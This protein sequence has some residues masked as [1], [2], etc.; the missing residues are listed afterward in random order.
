MNSFYFSFFRTKAFIL[1]LVTAFF[2][3]YAMAQKPKE[4]NP[5]E[6]SLATDEKIDTEIRGNMS[7]NLDNGLPM[8]IYQVNFDVPAGTPE[9][10]AMYYL[11]HQH[12]KLG[13]PQNELSNLRHHATRTSRA[14][15]VVRYR[16]YSG[17][18][19]V[20]KAE[21]TITIS[22][23]NKVVYVMNS[24]E[25]NVNMANTQPSISQEVAY[26]LANDYLNI[27]GNIMF[28]DYRL[29]VY[30]NK[31]TTRLAYEVVIS[32]EGLSGEWHVYVDA[33][34][35]E[36]FKAV[37]MAHY[38]G[39]KDKDKKKKNSE[40]RMAVPVDGTG[41]VFNP[42]PLSSNQVNYGGGYVD[43]NDAAT[44]QLNNARFSV[45]LRDIDLTGGIYT[46]R[47]PR[48]EI[49]DFEGPTTGLFTQTSS[50]FNFTRFDQGFEAVNTYYHIDF[51]MGYVNE[52]LGLNI[53]PYQYTGGV[54]YDPHAAG[55][56]DNSYYSSGPGRL[57]F[58]EGCVDDAE[59]SD[60]IHHEL[61]HG[62]HDWVTSGGLSQVDGLSEGCGDY[63]AQSYN[64][65]LG[66]WTSA[67]PQY[68]WVFNWDGHNPCWPGRITN[69][70][71][72]YPTGLVGQIHTDGQI[73]ASCLMGIWDQIGQQEM[74]I[75][76]YEGLG[77][78][79]GSSSQN[80]AANAVY[81]AAV[82][83]NYTQAQLVIIHSSLEDCGYTLPAL[84]GPPIASFSSDTDTICLDN[85]TTI[86]FTDTTSPTATSWLWTFEGGT[87]A[88]STAQ[89]P[90]VTY[91]TEGT[92]DV[93][94][95]VTNEFGTDQVTITDYVTTL[96]GDNCPACTSSTNSTVVPISTGAGATYTSII[97][98]PGGG[99]IIDVNVTIN[100]THTWVSDLDISLISPAGTI[101]ELTSDNGDDGNNYINTVFD[102][103][104]TT[105][106]TSGTPPFTGTFLPEGNLSNLNGQDAAGNWTLRVVDDAF[107]DGGQI[108]S[109]TLD[110]CVEPPLSVNENE[111]EAFSIFPNPNDGSFTI[112]LNSS[113]GNNINVE[114]YDV[115]GR[116]IFKNVYATSANFNENISLK[117]VQSGMYLVKVSDGEREVTR[118]VIVE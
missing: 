83:L 16:Q 72:V 81:Q 76:F 58:G 6:I 65:S 52:T 35:Q 82:N 111:F 44:T 100:I 26:H 59:D 99:D 61:G 25:V 15:S 95:S 32:A 48:A 114:V 5:L 21:V 8:A 63:I 38:H 118:K 10:M 66:N 11:Q 53:M 92:F 50:T 87:P 77:M 70:S 71:A 20:N 86:A 40:Q 49:V 102:Q 46:L 107:Q 93:T 113:S 106:I 34:T 45:T 57:A 30:K 88:T 4:K 24:Y 89:N 105:P 85:D 62:L 17:D 109:W 98:V 43:G 75:I 94:L 90:T 110:V 55:G 33:L 56:A 2:N 9:D 97:N 117:N 13:I 42:D 54:R 12:K 18:Y 7:I 73:W 31:R 116:A 14:G 19:P 101:V 104:A 103:Q 84:P 60:V 79:N 47:G 27:T 96:S 51:L 64:R 74:D 22:P 3:F 91:A 68:N 78:T 37:D 67:N 29:M 115:R 108:N 28:S 112:K 80:D 69:Y 23:E 41:M 1:C 36:I 39:D